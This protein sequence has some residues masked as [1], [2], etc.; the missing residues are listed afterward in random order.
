[1]LRIVARLALV[2]ATALVLVPT[3]DAHADGGGKAQK[4]KATKQSVISLKTKLAKARDDMRTLADTPAPK[5]LT[6]EQKTTYDAEMVKV[7][8]LADDTE[9]TVE[10][11][12][13]AL[14]DA[15]TDLDSMSEMGEMESLR[16]QMAMDRLSKMMSTL[17]NL[18]KKISDTASQI[19]QNLK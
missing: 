18:L 5:G 9:V 3:S 4:P 2:S 12:D 14:E 17:S 11:L 7:R 6:A 19:T 15:K 1:M 13:K 10:K 16:L 8:G